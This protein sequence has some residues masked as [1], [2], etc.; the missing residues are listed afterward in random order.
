MREVA[1]AVMSKD[2]AGRETDIA[3]DHSEFAHLPPVAIERVAHIMRSE[4]MNASVSSIHINGWFGSHDKLEGAR[5]IVRE[6]LGRELDAELPPW[7]FVRDSTNDE[8]MFEAFPVHLPCE[9]RVGHRGERHRT[10]DH[11]AFRRR[12]RSGKPFRRQRRQA[13]RPACAMERR[14]T[15]RRRRRRP[16]RAFRSAWKGTARG[17]CPSIGALLRSSPDPSTSAPRPSR[18]AAGARLRPSLPRH[19]G[20]RRF[21]R[22]GRQVVTDVNLLVRRDNAGAES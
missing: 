20:R 2:S 7:V 17:R 18:C 21:T 1:G 13:S 9:Q 22:R 19:H 11:H 10:L 15:S 6:L 4:G 3:I 8:S 14:S 12:F 16:A 5:W